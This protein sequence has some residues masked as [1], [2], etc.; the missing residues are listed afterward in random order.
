MVSSKRYYHRAK[1]FTDKNQSAGGTPQEKSTIQSTLKLLRERVNKGDVVAVILHTEYDT[2]RQAVAIKSDTDSVTFSVETDDDGQLLNQPE[3]IVI[4]LSDPFQTELFSESDSATLDTEIEPHMIVSIQL[5]KETVESAPVISSKLQPI[6]VSVEGVSRTIVKAET[7]VKHSYTQ[8]ELRE[9]LI[10]SLQEI[11]KIPQVSPRQVETLGR[12]ADQILD[13]VSINSAAQESILAN[14]IKRDIFI[15]D[16]ILPLVYDTKNIYHLEKDNPDFAEAKRV[17]YINLGLEGQGAGV[18]GVGDLLDCYSSTYSQRNSQIRSCGFR[19]CPEQQTS[20][21]EWEG[22][23]ESTRP[24]IPLADDFNQSECAQKNAHGLMLSYKEYKYLM[25][26]GGDLQI[27]NSS[28]NT[29]HINIPPESSYLNQAHQRVVSTYDD[30]DYT[31]IEGFGDYQEDSERSD[32]EEGPVGASVSRDDN[33]PWTKLYQNL[34]THTLKKG[35]HRGT[36]VVRFANAQFDGGQLLDCKS[37]K[38]D[39]TKCMLFDSDSI[40]HRYAFG[41]ES[42]ICDRVDSDLIVGRTCD[43]SSNR[44][45]SLYR[46]KEINQENTDGKWI[47]PGKE[48]QRKIRRPPEQV[49]YINGEELCLVGYAWMSQDKKQFYSWGRYLEQPI[50]MN[51]GNY[52]SVTIPGGNRAMQFTDILKSS[53]VPLQEWNRW[54]KNW[55]IHATS[56]SIDAPLNLDQNQLYLFQLTNDKKELSQTE[57]YAFIQSIIPTVDQLILSQEHQLAQCQNLFDVEKLLSVYNCTLDDIPS[58]NLRQLFRK[59]RNVFALSSNIES[60][61]QQLVTRRLRLQIDFLEVARGFDDYL[62]ETYYSFHKLPQLQVFNLMVDAFDSY[63]QEYSIDKLFSYLQYLGIGKTGDDGKYVF[64]KKFARV[65]YDYYQVLARIP[66]LTE[67]TTP[68]NVISSLSKALSSAD[69]APELQR[70]VAISLVIVNLLSVYQNDDLSSEL[71]TLVLGNDVVSNTLETLALNYNMSVPYKPATKYYY[72]SSSRSNLMDTKIQQLSRFLRKTP[73]NSNLYYTLTKRIHDIQRLERLDNYVD[74]ELGFALSEESLT[75]LRDEY[76]NYKDKYNE[77]LRKFKF[78]NQHCH[79]QRV[80]KSYF[81][82][83]EM[84]DDNFRD[85]A[86]DKEYDTLK[87]D[88]KTVQEVVEKLCAEG[89]QIN[90]ESQGTLSFKVFPDRIKKKY[91]VREDSDLATQSERLL[92][93]L[94]YS[95]IENISPLSSTDEIQE[96]TDQAIHS[97]SQGKSG[98]LVTLVK[99]GDW[100]LLT[101]DSNTYLNQRVKQIWVPK[102]PSKDG[103]NRES[104]CVGDLPTVDELLRGNCEFYQHKCVSRRLQRWAS[105]MNKKRRIYKQVEGLLGQRKHLTEA[106]SDFSNVVEKSIRELDGWKRLG[107]RETKLRREKSLQIIHQNQKTE[108]KDIQQKSPLHLS[109]EQSLNQIRIIP[110]VDRRQSLMADLI[111][112]RGSYHSDS[113]N[114]TW[115]LPGR[116]VMCCA[117]HV[118]MSQLAYKTGTERQTIQSAL[119]AKWGTGVMNGRIYCRNC[120]EELG[121]RDLVDQVTFDDDGNPAQGPAISESIASKKRESVETYLQPEQLTLYN[122]FMRPFTDRY[123]QLVPEI[124]ALDAEAQVIQMIRQRNS[125]VSYSEFVQTVIRDDSYP[126]KSDFPFP[127]SKSE[128]K[129]LYDKFCN[130]YLEG[131][132]LIRSIWNVRKK[133][134]QTKDSD[135]IKDLRGKKNDF[136]KQL[137]DFLREKQISLDSARPLFLSD[138]V[139]LDSERVEMTDLLKQKDSKSKKKPSPEQQK[140]LISYVKKVSFLYNAYIV[141]LSYTVLSEKAQL[142]GGLTELCLQLFTKVPPYRVYGSG[143]ERKERLVLVWG[144][145]SPEL[146]EVLQNPSKIQGLELSQKIQQILGTPQ[147]EFISYL[148]RIVINQ[149][150][151]KDTQFPPQRDLESIISRSIGPDRV[152]SDKQKGVFAEIT[153]NLMYKLLSPDGFQL[154]RDKFVWDKTQT[155]LSEKESISTYWPSFRPALGKPQTITSDSI[156]QA[157]QLQNPSETLGSMLVDIVNDQINDSESLIRIPKKGNRVQ[158]CCPYRVDES[159]L[160]SMYQDNNLLQR[161][162]STLGSESSSVTHGELVSQYS[163]SLAPLNN[164]SYFYQLDK[165][166]SD[167][168]ATQEPV[169]INRAVKSLQS[170]IK[171]MYILFCFEEGV[172]GKRRIYEKIVDPYIANQS[173]FWKNLSE[174]QQ[175]VEETVADRVD[176]ILSSRQTFSSTLKQI[177]GVDRDHL[178][179]SLTLHLI[180]TGGVAYR[181]TVTNKF[182]LEIQQEVNQLV[183][184]MEIDALKKQFLHMKSLIHRNL[185]ISMSSK[186]I[187]LH[188]NDALPI[189]SLS[190]QGVRTTL[191]L[192][193]LLDSYLSVFPDNDVNYFLEPILKLRNGYSDLV[194][195]L[196]EIWNHSDKQSLLDDR[197]TEIWSQSNIRSWTTSMSQFIVGCFNRVGVTTPSCFREEGGFRLFKRSE[198]MRERIMSMSVMLKSQMTYDPIT[199]EIARDEVLSDLGYIDHTSPDG[200]NTIEVQKVVKRFRDFT[201]LNFEAEN[202]ELTKSLL[203]VL[204]R[205]LPGPETQWLRRNDSSDDLWVNYLRAYNSVLTCNYSPETMSIFDIS[206]GIIVT[207]F[208]FLHSIY[209]YLVGQDVLESQESGF[210]NHPLPGDTPQLNHRIQ[211]LNDGIFSTLETRRTVNSITDQQ[212]LQFV[213]QQR[214]EKDERNKKRVQDLDKESKDTYN[215][216]R[217]FNLGKSHTSHTTGDIIQEETAEEIFANGTSVQS[218]QVVSHLAEAESYTDNLA[219]RGGQDEQEALLLDLASDED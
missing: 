25:R 50:T 52:A 44:V 4:S 20:R 146:G 172:F 149:P 21:A 24:I 147:L 28:D 127:F 215:I 110:D 31:M 93:S 156:S 198:K 144:G 84:I 78:F 46:A 204:T 76:N 150:N 184:D 39:G 99:E 40:R 217:M 86:V 160:D 9:S 213:N 136:S 53:L 104:L 153:R 171:Q 211:Q 164:L 11:S 183:D 97:Y 54:N 88:Y 201:D 179:G 8:Q 161:V 73:D 57:K 132:N 67:V 55:N 16:S 3:T 131:A 58:L 186:Q 190:L 192:G 214:F 32:D 107:K 113:D 38:D 129:S 209:T 109:L 87:Q 133:G 154:L 61:H 7:T 189:E 83:S 163:G 14:S 143:L 17:N 135:H 200:Y 151:F 173:Q 96:R 48:F 168:E 59:I 199:I 180:K 1:Y 10:S 12:R 111:R 219:E 103:E 120:G 5:T 45:D 142:I 174:D 121:Y 202:L 26:K 41:P 119:F 181:D 68:V 191:V 37:T 47:I 79:N 71:S 6:K 167:A 137:Q 60:S 13:V 56:N 98:R 23:E 152:M 177:T 108:D 70:S 112:Q 175:S 162:L 196:T 169:L 51:G 27:D 42:I 195:E 2:Q 207:Q 15:S 126:G 139:I 82:K 100:A 193:N 197:K 115:N 134:K 170:K 64:Q 65:L 148:S 101:T 118:V 81:S 141:S 182:K 188:L 114:I 122:R 117:H 210:L 124:S 176:E 66:R 63:T 72:N 203:A 206:D 36:E 49:K 130:K 90:S 216:Y 185:K 29:I 105:N 34:S 125:I 158:S 22:Q 92:T 123:L 95:K 166:I 75:S 102:N 62:L 218:D 18:L 157:E 80:V 187:K 43:G 178:V 145:F 85:V 194:S 140:A 165:E 94:V 91:G 205:E 106:L 155:T 159:Y 138:T 116:P 33:L 35:L 77:E 69:N 128:Y 208:L 74:K 19:R 212:L 89:C 30:T